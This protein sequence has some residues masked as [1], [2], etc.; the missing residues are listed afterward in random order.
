MKETLILLTGSMYWNNLMDV[1]KSIN[2]YYDK[3]K[4]KFNIIWLICKDQYNGKGN[5]DSCIDYLSTTNIDYIIKDSGLPNQKNY[6]GDLFNIPLQET[7]AERN[8]D[9]AWVYVM[10]D[11]NILHPNLFYTFNKIINNI[12]TTNRYGIILTKK[13][14][15]GHVHEMHLQSICQQCD[16]NIIYIFNIPDP[17]QCI[18]KYSFIKNN[19]FI[20]G[21]VNYDYK[22]Y[23]P[24][25]RNNKDKFIYYN[26]YNGWISDMINAYH[27]NLRHLED[28]DKFIND[29][30][31]KETYID[32]AI[33]NEDTTPIN[34]PILSNEAQEKI[35]N[36]IKQELT[37]NKK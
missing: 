14:M 32:V 28:I 29:F 31:N 34:F 17:S 30:N 33:Q 26:E 23:V 9:D 5:I 8:L 20:P 1:A 18:L 2:L 12:D 13:S 4:D 37:N 16:N 15:A 6:G 11:D 7:I 27:N 21:E 10:D 19:G 35:I 36:I 24:T 3:Y 25:I 22:W